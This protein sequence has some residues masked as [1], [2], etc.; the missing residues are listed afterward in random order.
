[1]VSNQ[2]GEMLGERYV[3]EYDASSTQRARETLDRTRVNANIAA[4]LNI[5]LWPNRCVAIASLA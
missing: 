1:M 3:D 5:S 2:F 4:S